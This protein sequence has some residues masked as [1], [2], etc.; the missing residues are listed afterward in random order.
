MLHGYSPYKGV[1]LVEICQNVVNNDVK[2]SS[3]INTNAK[4][5]IRSI[6]ILDT[7][8]RPTI[9]SIVKNKFLTQNL[10]FAQNSPVVKKDKSPVNL[11]QNGS[12]QTN[13]NNENIVINKSS[14]STKKLLSSSNQLYPGSNNLGNNNN[15][16]LNI[17]RYL[18]DDKIK[19]SSNINNNKIC[20]NNNYYNNSWVNSPDI[21]GSCDN[22]NINIGSGTALNSISTKFCSRANNN[23]LSE[24]NVP[25]EVVTSSV[26][27][28]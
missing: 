18:T 13:N 15:K 20:D 28:R 25:H 27:N 23:I 4:E 2:F 22:R 24:R 11:R 3:L 21:A 12:F 9:D 7:N 1:S 16:N 19:D 6:L 10:N 26:K 17:I 14:N 5:L 8:S